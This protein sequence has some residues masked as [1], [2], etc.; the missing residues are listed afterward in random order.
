LVASFPSAGYGTATDTTECAPLNTS[1]QLRF[2]RFLR[3]AAAVRQSI[4]LYTGSLDNRIALLQPQYDVVERVVEYRLPAN[5]LLEPSTLYTVELVLPSE[6]DAF[7]FRAFDDA[8]LGEGPVPTRFNFFTCAD[9]PAEE[10]M[11][12]PAASCA[13]VYA[14]LSGAQGSCVGADCHGGTEPRMGLLLEPGNANNLRGLEDTAIGQVAHQTEVGVNA[15]SPLENPA[16]FGVQ[17]PLIDPNSPGNS[18]LLYKLLRKRS[19]YST[20]GGGDECASRYPNLPADGDCVAPEAA[21]SQ[22]LREWFVRGEPMPFENPANPKPPVFRDGLR[23]I[24]SWIAAGA[25]CDN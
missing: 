13:D 6:E 22:R 12:E 23:Q 1:I 2:N 15:R 17:M 11:L 20:S 3:P 16:R 5:T 24:Q 7:G 9:P 14:I 25:L 4:V 8:P 18:Y 21:E 10:P 19:N